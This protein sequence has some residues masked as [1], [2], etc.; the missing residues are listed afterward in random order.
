MK[1]HNN[2]V[3]VKEQIVNVRLDTREFDTIQKSTNIT[4]GS[5]T[6]C[7]QIVLEQNVLRMPY[8]V[9]AHIH[10]HLNGYIQVERK[11]L[12]FMFLCCFATIDNVSHLQSMILEVCYTIVHVS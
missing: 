11:S 4:V 2:D 7:C 10:V 8:P 3:N 9:R 1:A 12:I 5:V 6:H